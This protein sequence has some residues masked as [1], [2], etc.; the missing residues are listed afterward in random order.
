MCLWLKYEYVRNL[1][2]RKSKAD[3]DLQI[4]INI[5]HG[6]RNLIYLIEANLM[7]VCLSMFRLKGCQLRW[8]HLEHK[9]P[10]RLRSL[11]E[12]MIHLVFHRLKF[13]LIKI[14]RETIIINIFQFWS[15]KKQIGKLLS[16]EWVFYNL[17]LLIIRMKDKINHFN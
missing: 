10:S 7:V 9:S 6:L 5:K 11:W 13:K 1:Q 14:Y 12:S 15:H 3:L 17:D 16:K 8:H 2:H 4:S